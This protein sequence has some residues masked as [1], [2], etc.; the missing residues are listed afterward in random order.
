M[1]LGSESSADETLSTIDPLEIEDLQLLIQA[2]PACLQVQLYIR[3]LFSLSLLNV[4][5]FISVHRSYFLV[6]RFHSWNPH[7]FKPS[8][9]T[10]IAQLQTLE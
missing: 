10:Q 2:L 4:H 3:I 7:T 5:T 1:R 8:H 6:H 9:Y